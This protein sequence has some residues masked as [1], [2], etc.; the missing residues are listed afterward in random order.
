MTEVTNLKS[1]SIVQL[2]DAITNAESRKARASAELVLLHAE[3][4]DRFR[5]QAN[6][7]FSAAGKNSGDLTITTA[8]GMKFKASISKTVKWDSTKLREIASTM[9]WPVV[10]R[11]FKMDFSVPEATFKAIPDEALLAKIT[12]ARTVQYG[13]LTIKP[14][15]E[16]D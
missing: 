2:R 10:Q 16:K 15:N 9:E 13:S 8:S 7:M 14:I 4:E 3:I 5:E 6:A 11:L 12:D 1:L